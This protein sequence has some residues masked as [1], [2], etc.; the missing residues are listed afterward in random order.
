[1]ADGGGHRRR[2]ALVEGYDVTSADGK[3]EPSVDAPF[4]VAGRVTQDGLLV[5]GRPVPGST[6][7]LR[8]E[9]AR[10]GQPLSG[11]RRPR[12]RRSR[13]ELTPRSPVRARPSGCRR[14]DAGRAAASA[15]RNGQ[16]A[17]QRGRHHARRARTHRAHARV[18]RRATTPS[19]SWWLHR[20]TRRSNPSQAPACHRRPTRRICRLTLAPPSR[21]PVMTFLSAADLSRPAAGLS[22]PCAVGVAARCLRMRRRHPTP[23][24]SPPRPR[25]VSCGV[26]DC[27]P[28]YASSSR[29]Q[30]SRRVGTTG[31]LPRRRARRKPALR[32]EYCRSSQ[33]SAARA[34]FSTSAAFTA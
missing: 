22:R 3:S 33:E 8:R 15:G 12:G 14:R 11:R 23:G 24:R 30:S 34:H 4:G 29:S 16:D 21:T 32:I 6:V 1:M 25:P 17:A 18:L 26:L 7:P 31:R 10:A 9:F 2:K 27:R 28:R 19:A 13:R 5:R 20:P